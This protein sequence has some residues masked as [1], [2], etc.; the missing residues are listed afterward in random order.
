[1]SESTFETYRENVSAYEAGQLDELV[2]P[3]C[4]TPTVA[5]RFSPSP[6]A[7][8]PSTTYFLCSVCGE[9]DTAQYRGAPPHFDE[10]REFEG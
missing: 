3:R 5:V 8:A 4:G 1:M 7:A 9:L 2:C 6:A 10:S